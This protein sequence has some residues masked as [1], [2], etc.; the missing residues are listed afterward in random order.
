MYLF[1]GFPFCSIDLFVYKPW[2]LEDINFLKRFLSHIE[3]GYLFAIFKEKVT[4]PLKLLFLQKVRL[5]LKSFL[6]VPAISKIVET[7]SVSDNSYSLYL[8]S[9]FHSLSF[10]TTPLSLGSNHLSILLLPSY[11]WMSENWGET[12]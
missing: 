1:L 6:V 12:N 10:E 8:Y 9:V 4:G 2:T 3:G 5:I 11:S 7:K